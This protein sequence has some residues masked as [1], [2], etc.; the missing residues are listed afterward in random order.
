V[1]IPPPQR[2]SP[3]PTPTPAPA[4]ED[5]PDEEPPP[6]RSGGFSGPPD[7]EIRT[8]L[9]VAFRTTPPDAFV[10]VDGTQIGRATEWNGLKGNRTFSLDGAGE[11][12]IKIRSQ[13][14]KEV[15]IL[16]HASETAGVTPIFARLQPM[17]AA[18]AEASD[19]KA[20]RVREAI[21]FRVEPPGATILVDGQTVGSANLYAGRFAQP[22]TW[23]KL[24]PGRH[25]VGVTAP[26]MARQDFIVEVSPGADKD[27]D[28]IEVTLQPGA[29]G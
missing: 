15:R 10:L 9:E 12:T 20:Y 16:V 7:L 29:G 2:P 11:H 17:A 25:R 26:G 21:A 13:G 1:V 24:P 6:R 8:G 3:T 19:L 22:R 18:Q 14:L 27:R 4:K 23:L 28:R 5:E